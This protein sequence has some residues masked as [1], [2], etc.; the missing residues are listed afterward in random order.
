MLAVIAGVESRENRPVRILTTTPLRSLF[1]FAF[2]LREGPKP[3]L[4]SVLH[5]FLRLVLRLLV[6]CP[7][8]LKRERS[9]CLCL[10]DPDCQIKSLMGEQ[11]VSLENLK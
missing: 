7:A 6:L 9:S 3:F 4:G 8:V 11:G 2:H 10:H 1:I 5:F